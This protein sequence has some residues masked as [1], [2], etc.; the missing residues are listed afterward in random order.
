[1]DFQ[2]MA[3]SFFAPTCI[4]S[5]EKTPQGG[6]G[7][8]K[9]VAGNRKYIEAL[10]HSGNRNVPHLPGIPKIFSEPRKFVPDSPYVNY[11]PKDLGFENICYRSAVMKLP[12]HT[13]VYLDYIKMWFNIFAMP[14]DIETGNICYCAYTVIESDNCDDDTSATRGDLFSDAVINTCIKLHSTKDLAKTMEDVILDIRQLC[15]ADVCSLILTD[16]AARSYTML[17]SSIDENCGVKRVT[18]FDCFNDIVESWLYMFKDNDRLLIRNQEDMEYIRRENPMWYYN[19]VEAGVDSLVFFQLKYDN[20]VIGFMW[21]TNFDIENTI[22]IKETLELTTFFI[23]SK[24]S[25]YRMLEHLKR[26]SY[27]DQ[28]TGIP[29]RIACTEMIDGLIK[30][31]E[32]FSL[33]SIDINSFKSIN[34]TMGFE[35]GNKVLKEVASRWKKIVDEK[36]TNTNDHLARMGGDE[37]SL[38]IQGY[39]SDEDIQQTIQK[40]S[41]ALS[42]PMTIDDCDLYINASFGYCLYPDDADTLDSLI[43]SANASMSEVKRQNSSNHI[44]RFTPELLKEERT[45]EIERKLI[46]A[47]ENGTIFFCLQPQ[48]DISHKL[49]GFEAL[50]RMKD[51]DGKIIS[52][53]EFIPVAE[54]VGLVDKVDGTVFRKSAMFIGRLIRLTGAEIIL[55]VNVSVRHLMKNDFLDEVRDIIAVSGIPADHLEIEITESIMIDS[56]EK[57]LHCI[58]ELH[59]MGIQIAIDDFGTGYSSLS[60]LNNFPANILKIDKSF[61]DKMCSGDSAKQYVAAIISIGHIM[62]FDVISEGVEEAEQLETLKEIGCDFIQGFIWGKPLPLEEAEKLIM[63][64]SGK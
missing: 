11:F 27:T 26:I 53:G 14:I 21:A 46:N 4:I 58:D 60:Y 42:A 54:K 57:A 2:K 25:E 18:D 32:T 52:P 5:V 6:Y 28:L 55:S 8:I 1:M 41:E 45:L 39:S 49:R 15:K 47:L 61:I 63:E 24:L 9:L 36:L 29:N 12:V 20:E 17:A 37:F 31:F 13:H 62:G 33:V 7:Q 40:Y 30:H 51:D 43:S 64:H 23:S 50:A 59:K 22:R 35:A 19:L 48:F 56:A 16:T 44:M 10:E 34:D 38:V 3:D